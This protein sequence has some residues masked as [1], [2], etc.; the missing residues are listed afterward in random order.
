M[1]AVARA[2]VDAAGVAD[3]VRLVHA[4]ALDLDLKQTFSLALVALNSFGHFAEPGEPERVL[5]R[6]RQHLDPGGSL[7]LD[8]TN[9]TPGAFGNTEGLVIHDYTRPGPRPEW[10]TVKFRSQWQDFVAERIDVSCFY[11][12]VGPAGEVRRT[13]ASYALRY[14]YPSELRLLFERAGFAVQHMYGGYDLDPLTDSSERL[15]IVGRLPRRERTKP[16][17]RSNAI[18]AVARSSSEEA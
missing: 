1:L 15:L 6:L 8:L 3:R 2:K 18:T 16:F 17:R 4:N 14:F 12:E 7:A 11:D 10:Q 5:D 9:P 13:L